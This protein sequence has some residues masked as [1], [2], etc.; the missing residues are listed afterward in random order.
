MVVK[1]NKATIKVGNLSMSSNSNSN[2]SIDSELELVVVA[3]ESVVTNVID[4]NNND[5]EIQID[6]A[7][8]NNY[9][10]IVTL[11]IFIKLL[12]KNYIN[13]QKQRNIIQNL[14]Y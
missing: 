12:I 9:I 3:E 13:I 1:N 8:K 7:N 11:N 4:I 14:Q 10:D 5:A 6:P 2:I